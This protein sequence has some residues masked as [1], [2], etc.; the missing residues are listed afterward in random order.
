[1]ECYPPIFTPV[2]PSSGGSGGGGS[3]PIRNETP[4][5]AIDGVNVAFGLAHVPI[6]GTTRVYLLGVRLQS[7]SGNDYTV[8]GSTLTFESGQVP[9]TGAWI[10][11]DYEY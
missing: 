1:M 10:L 3:T 4:S 9:Q 8:S 11:V 5:G 7:G 6:G 2:F